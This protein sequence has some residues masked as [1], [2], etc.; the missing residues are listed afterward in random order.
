M[1]LFLL[2]NFKKKMKRLDDVKHQHY[3]ILYFIWHELL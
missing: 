1:F 3:I 2:M